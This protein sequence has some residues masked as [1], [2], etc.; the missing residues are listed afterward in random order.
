MQESSS[1]FLL[2]DLLQDT[3]PRNQQQ[4]LNTTDFRISRFP[5]KPDC[6]STGRST[7]LHP[8]RLVGRPNLTESL[9]LTVRELRST[10]SEPCACCACRSTWPVDRPACFS[11][12]AAISSCYS[13]RLRRRLPRRSLDDPSTILI[14]FPISKLS[15]S[16][17]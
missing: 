12:A 14:N 1:L 15:L 9:A 17:S 2:Q 11:A 3:N 16:N 4:P 7:D 5:P 8:G 10:A 13:L 6:R